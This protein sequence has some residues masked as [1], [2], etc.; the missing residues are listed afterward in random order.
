MLILT[1]CHCIV[2]AQ[3]NKQQREYFLKEQLKTIKKVI[4]C[5]FSI[6]CI[7]VSYRVAM[8]LYLG[9]GH[10]EGRQG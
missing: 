1:F 3:V 2:F 10:G 5:V 8:C 6:H 9:T 7:R 4:S